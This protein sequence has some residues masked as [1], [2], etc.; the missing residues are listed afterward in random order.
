MRGKQNNDHY[1][2]VRFM[3]SYLSCYSLINHLYMTLNAMNRWTSI[4]RHTLCMFLSNK[5]ISY[6]VLNS[7]NCVRWMFIPTE[8]CT[9]ESS[10][11]HSEY[12]MFYVC[13][14][15]WSLHPMTCSSTMCPPLVEHIHSSISNGSKFT[16]CPLCGATGDIHHMKLYSSSKSHTELGTLWWHW[17]SKHSKSTQLLTGFRKIKTPLP[18]MDVLSV[19]S[20]KH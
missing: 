9:N 16:V 15:V 2:S 17:S 20:F 12:W 13:I 7:Q 11:V 1:E 8:H 4:T 19:K 6:C 3:W 14:S 10:A 5:S 18:K